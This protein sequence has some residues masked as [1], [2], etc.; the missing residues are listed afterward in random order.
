MWYSSRPQSTYNRIFNFVVLPLL[1]TLDLKFSLFCS[2]MSVMST[3]FANQ[4]QG[5]TL[6]AAIAQSVRA[7]V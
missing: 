4:S 6:T 3:F 1:A 5:I 2:G 7:W